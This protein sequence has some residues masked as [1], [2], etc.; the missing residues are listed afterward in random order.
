MI[1]RY[2]FVGW[3]VFLTACAAPRMQ[4]GHDHAHDH[5]H[6]HAHAGVEQEPFG[7]SL[8]KGWTE[9]WHH[10]HRSV[11]NTPMVHGVLTEPAFLCRDLFLTYERGDSEAALEAEL[12]F[13]LSRR[14][15][16]IVEGGYE[17]SDDE[18][19]GAADSALGLRA[20]WGDTARLLFATSLEV[21][22]PTGNGEWGAGFIGHAWIDVGW[23]TTLQLELG[24]ERFPSVNET[25]FPWGV[26]VIK[27]FD[28]G[29][30]KRR[31]GQVLS[32]LAEAAGET[33][34]DGE[35]EGQWFAGVSYDTG[36]FGEFRGGFTRSFAGENGFILG[37]IVH[38]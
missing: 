12:E 23:W 31:V 5:E 4:D 33:D 2:R 9:K 24:V 17:W 19:N 3:L 6:D 25:A 16:L 18:G 28:L 21:E 37:V 34:R 1:T 10:T 35:T 32:I 20:L 36:N 30:G 22:I 29:A 14:L 27:S 38:F 13:A 7:W 26:S 15:G 8:A 11:R